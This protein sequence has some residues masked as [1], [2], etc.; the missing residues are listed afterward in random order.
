[1][2]IVLPFY[3]FYPRKLSKFVSCCSLQQRKGSGRLA[4]IKN[5]KPSN[6]LAQICAKRYHRLRLRPKQPNTAS[7][8]QRQPKPQAQAVEQA[9]R[10]E[11]M[12]PDLLPQV[13]AGTMALHMRQW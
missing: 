1:M 13:Q 7:Q 3:E 9:A 12:A 11:K 5:R 2:K 6:R 10:V 8:Q 4:A